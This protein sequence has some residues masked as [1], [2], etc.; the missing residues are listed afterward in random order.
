MISRALCKYKRMSPRKARLVA[1]QVRGE[2]LDMALRKVELI[3]QKS[4]ALIKQILK[5]AFSNIKKELALDEADL[6]VSKIT[7]DGG[8]VL[9]RYRAEPMGRASVLR[10]PTSHIL[11]ELDRIKEK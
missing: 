2:R 10:K 9:K 3:N 1:D 7:V 4:A 5:D 11:V 6:Y 8:P